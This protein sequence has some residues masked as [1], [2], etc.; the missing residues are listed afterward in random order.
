MYVNR[1]PLVEPYIQAKTL[2]DF[3]PITVPPNKLFVLGDNRNDSYDS[4]YWGFV[5]F[6]WVIGQAD[7]IYWPPAHVG[8]IKP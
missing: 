4:R 7:L 3:G 8:L 6:S 1:Q 5:D 2:G